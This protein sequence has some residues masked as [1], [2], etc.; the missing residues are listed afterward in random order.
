MPKQKKPRKWSASVK[1]DSLEIPEGM[2]L[3]ND[4]HLIALAVKEAA[5]K[6]TR[7]KSPPYASGMSYLCFYI[8]RGGRNIPPK[9]R[10]IIER[11][12][13]ELRLLFGRPTRSV[14]AE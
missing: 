10:R 1:T 9:R 2:F 4:P 6:S 8:N 11:A 3:K 5:E 7:R 13:K 12:K 14:S